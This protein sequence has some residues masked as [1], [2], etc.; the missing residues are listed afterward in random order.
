MS[1]CGEGEG[2]PDEDLGTLVVS[3]VV[4]SPKVNVDAAAKE[5]AAFWAAIALPH[6][7][8]SEQIGA[9]LVEGTSSVQV[10][11][12]ENTLEELQ[13]T[14]SL[15]IDGEDRYRFTLDNSKEYGRHATFDGQYLYL[16]PR[17]GPYHKRTPQ[18]ES[19]AA[20]HRNEAF[21][22]ASDYLELFRGQLEVS[23]GGAQTFAGRA[24]RIV[25][26]KNSPDKQKRAESSLLQKKWRQSIEVSTL[27]GHA[28]LDA[29]TGAVL[30]LQFKGSLSFERDGKTQNMTIAAQRSVSEIGHAEA[31]AAPDD[32]T[33]LE[34]PARRRQLDERDR[35]L[36]GIAPPAR[37]APTPKAAAASENP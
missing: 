8:L 1:A 27:D 17:F 20:K 34:I 10:S 15:R 16:R 28:A 2:R 14:L 6:A 30:D 9:H 24:V 29:Q 3:P 5:S 32:A 19:E 23:D 26:F 11:E 12:E 18:N 37:K 4:A 31:I 7:W 35:L 13:D 22:G 36:K 25:R 21:A 33:L